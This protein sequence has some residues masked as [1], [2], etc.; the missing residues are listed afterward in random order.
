MIYKI[1]I[2]HNINDVYLSD[3][4]IKIGEISNLIA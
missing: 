3:G 4:M 2:L 1:A